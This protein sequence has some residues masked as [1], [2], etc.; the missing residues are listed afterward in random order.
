MLTRSAVAVTLL[1]VPAALAAD[2]APPPAPTIEGWTVKS[3]NVIP[4]AKTAEIAKK[5]G[6]KLTA[7]R[8]TVYDV[9]GEKVQVN[10][11]VAADAAEADKLVAA[12]TKNKAPWSCVKKGTTVY[13]LVGSNKAADAM[14]KAS[15]TLSGG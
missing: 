9:K 8:N 12:I 7:L 14:K 2:E 15:A 11:M 1:L 10:V 13:E 3:D 5:L 4:A 6:G